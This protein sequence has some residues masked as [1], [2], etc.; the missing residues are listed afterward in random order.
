MSL[1]V[2]FVKNIIYKNKK[3]NFNVKSIFILSIELLYFDIMY[4]VEL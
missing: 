4:H 1:I 3:V 2:I